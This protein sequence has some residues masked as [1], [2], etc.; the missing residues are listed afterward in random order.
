MLLH[1]QDTICNHDSQQHTIIYDDIH[2]KLMSLIYTDRN[3]LYQFLK[4]NIFHVI[5]SPDVSISRL[6][7]ET[8]CEIEPIH[9]QAITCKIF[10]KSFEDMIHDETICWS[11]D[12]TIRKIFDDL[13]AIRTVISRCPILWLLFYDIITK[14]KLKHNISEKYNSPEYF[15]TLNRTRIPITYLIDD[16]LRPSTINMRH[17]YLYRQKHVDMKSYG[18]NS[19]LNRKDKTFLNNNKCANIIDFGC[20]VGSRYDQEF[21]WYKYDPCVEKFHDLPDQPQCGL[22][23]YD[24]LEHIPASELSN[25]A[26]WIDILSTKCIIL[27]ISTRT[28]EEVLIDHDSG[29]KENAHCTVRPPKWWIEWA[30]TTYRQ[31]HVS[32]STEPKSG[33]QYV[34]LH[35]TK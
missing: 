32:E 25:V 30:K 8:L 12:T 33:K 11:D 6:M 2:I 35:I 14:N 21:S 13:Y 18:S 16:I 28:A 7:L 22:I 27:G 24:V 9:H 20:G 1:K 26:E 31:Y 19:T 15:K 23:S 10:I 5:N 3:K 34:T 17:L 29:I 4:H